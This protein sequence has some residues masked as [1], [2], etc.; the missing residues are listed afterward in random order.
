MVEEEKLYLEKKD[1]INGQKSLVLAQGKREKVLSLLGSI[2]KSGRNTNDLTRRLLS[3]F[4]RQRT[5]L[6]SIE[7]SVQSDAKDQVL[8]SL[9]TLDSLLLK[10]ENIAR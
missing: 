4:K 6:Q 8:D 7:N 1:N 2:K 9:K 10:L 3:S 5:L